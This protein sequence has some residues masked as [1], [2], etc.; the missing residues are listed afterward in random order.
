MSTDLSVLV[1]VLAITFW[2]PI[3]KALLL[4]LVFAFVGC[5]YALIFLSGGRR[6]PPQPPTSPASPAAGVYSIQPGD[7]RVPSTRR[8]RVPPTEQ[9]KS[10]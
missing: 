3:T 6:R 5:A 7:P 1:I 2:R 9:R 10:S 8:F 4:L